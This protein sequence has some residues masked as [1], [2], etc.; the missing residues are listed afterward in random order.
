[1]CNKT[2]IFKLVF[3]YA[4]SVLVFLIR[5]PN[6][7]ANDNLLRKSYKITSNDISSY[8]CFLWENKDYTIGAIALIGGSSLL[9][10]KGVRHYVIDH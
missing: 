6:L 9:I 8:P 2:Y 3:L 1:M 10:D 5:V 7:Y 4:L